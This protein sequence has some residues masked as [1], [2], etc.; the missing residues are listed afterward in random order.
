MT[1]SCHALHIHSSVLQYRAFDA[2]LFIA[3][4]LSWVCHSAL[5]HWFIQARFEI[6]H[7]IL[8]LSSSR[9]TVS[10][11]FHGTWRWNSVAGNYFAFRDRITPGISRLDHCCVRP[12]VF[13]WWCRPVTAAQRCHLVWL[14]KWRIRKISHPCLL[15]RHNFYGCYMPSELTSTF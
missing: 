11:D 6:L 9:H 12:F 10:T 2:R 4:L 5:C 3:V 14:A 7:A 8:P 1:D 13:N 15:V